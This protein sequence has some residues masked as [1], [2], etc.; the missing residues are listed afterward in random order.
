[1]KRKIIQVLKFIVLFSIGILFLWLAFRS[2][3]FKKLAE[4]LKKA[5]YYWL[6]LSVFFA[7]VA[8]LSRSR[9]WQLLIHPLGYKPSF[10]NTFHSMMF[11]YLANLAL[12]RAGEITRCVAL[13]KKERIPVDQL[14]GTV[15]IERTIDL[16][17]VFILLIIVV[18]NSSTIVNEWLKKSIFIPLKEKIFSVFGSTWILWI[19]AAFLG[20]V[21]LFL[22]IKY[23]KKL[24]KIKFFL[25]MFDLAKGVINGLKSITKLQRKWEFIFHTVIIWLSYALMTWVVVFALESTSDISFRESIFILVI[26][27]LAMS[28]PV[29]GGIGAFHYIVSRGI[30]V[31]QGVPLE[32]GLIYALLTH[33]SQIL[34][35]LIIGPVSFLMLFGRNIRGKNSSPGPEE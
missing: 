25:R 2:V 1:M 24:K 17:S 4:G 23:R 28:L 32:D 34:F 22:L 19:I 15:I 31:L 8:Y 3:D 29:Q 9:R 6:L 13:G 26:G 30:V 27:G 5:N 12:P 7:I 10:R 11:G 14:V 35:E 18:M 33:E 21:A 20:L 16:L